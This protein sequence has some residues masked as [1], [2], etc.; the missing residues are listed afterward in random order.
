MKDSVLKNLK[1]PKAKKQEFFHEKFGSKRPDPYYWLKQRDTRPVL[2]YLKKENHYAQQKLKPLEDLKNKLFDE[3][4]NRLPKK[5]NQEPV[6]FGDYFYYKTWEK[7]KQYPIYKRKNKSNSHEE[8][9][10]DVNSLKKQDNYLDVKNVLVS[11]DHNTLA[12]ALDSQ[13]REF[14]NIYFKNLKTGK[15]KDLF[16]TQA[17]SDFIW[18]KDNKTLF[19]TCQ[20]KKTLRAFQVYR[21]NTQTGKKEL[22]FE[23]PDLKFSVY[24]SKTLCESFITLLVNSNQTTEY[25]YLLA[26]QPEQ[27]FTLFCKRQTGH[28]Y[29]LNYGDNSF[30]ILSNKDQAFNFKLMKVPIQKKLLQE[31]KNT[32][33]SNPKI[34]LDKQKILQN[35]K[36]SKEMNHNS[37]LSQ[38]K[39]L[40]A[41][42]QGSY[43]SFLWQ[44]IIPHRPEVFIENYEVFKSFIALQVRFNGRQKIE[45]FDLKKQ[46]LH[47]IN[48]P[49]KIYSVCIGDNKEYNSAVVRLEFQAPNQ[50]QIIYDYKWNQKKLHFKSQKKIKGPFNSKNYILQEEYAVAQDGSQIPISLVYK[51]DIQ[52]GPAT[53]LLLYAYGSYGYSLDP[54]FS[55][56]NLSLLDRGFVYA[57]AHIRG[58][59]EKGRKWYEKGKLLNKKN[60]FSDFICCAQHLI[61]K[62]YT[63]PSH[64]YIMGGSAGGLLMGAVLNQRPDLFRAVVASVPFVDCLTTMLDKNIPLSTGEYEEWGNPNEK[65]YY[66]Y[67]QSYS[68]YDN[69][70]KTKYPHILIQTGYHDPRVQYWEPAKWTAKLRDHKTDDHLLLLLT[71]MESGHFGSTGRLELF[72]LYS[73]YFAFFIGIQ[74]NLIS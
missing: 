33:N 71:N 18:A 21:F 36:N 42:T 57:L 70:K 51:K 28:E 9:I 54:V 43:P 4:K 1:T 38:Q 34:F 27:N 44:D 24:L 50:A 67:I 39:T 65:K 68:P 13:G 63:S 60:T 69:V 29:H 59:S 40:P 3:M 17:T 53:P 11:S 20:D 8:M 41:D 61:E 12:Y 62:S 56:V 15:Q 66:D 47:K 22:V 64:L 10:L 45:I 32:D 37:A 74:K 55:S 49:E 30:Y 16:I 46:D 58:G 25:H 14:Y 23:E 7:E 73:L 72:K 5:E 52:L 6:P 26:H 19:Y 2:D 31:Q 35:Q 48:F